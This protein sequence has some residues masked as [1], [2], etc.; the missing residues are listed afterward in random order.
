MHWLALLRLRLRSLRRAHLD[1]ELDDEMAFHV[2]ALTHDYTS[3]GLSETDA[4]HAALRDM[5]AIAGRK[6]EC[7]D[8]RRFAGIET[9]LTDI[10]YSARTLRKS[11][12]FTSVV[13]A[14]LAL[15][16]GACTTIFAFA[17][18]VLLRPLPYPAADRIVVLNEHA[19]GTTDPLAVH[20]LN[21]LEWRARA[22]AFETLA[23]AQQPPLNV[24]GAQ[25]AEQVAR[26]M[27]TADFLRVFGS[28]PVVG[29]DFSEADMRTGSD[30][31]AILGYGFWQRWFGGDRNVVG[32]QLQ[33]PDGSL[34]IV[35]VAPRAFRLGA[36]EPD[37][38][39]ALA[40][41]PANPSAT[42]SRAF[43][44]YGRLARG[45]SLETARA[46]MSTIAADL[47]VRHRLDEGMGV[48]VS[49]LHD[50]LSK[51]AR[52]GLRLL[53]AVVAT[54]LAIACV[55]IAGLLMARSAGRRPE[56]ALRV[57]LGASRGRL[58]RQVVIES[59]LLALMGGAIGVALAAWMTRAL[60]ALAAGPLSLAAFEAVRV[61]AT[62]V[63]FTLVVASA[64]ALA[65]GLLPAVQASHVGPDAALRGQARGSSGDVRQHRVRR[66]LV[67]TEV[68]LAVVL[69]VG[70]G[71]LVRTLANLVR[72][73]LGFQPA[74]TLTM[75]L[76]LGLT[77][78]DARIGLVDRILDRVTVLPGVAA[79]GT[80]QFPPLRG[81][82]CGTGF[83]R[84]EHAAAQDP[85]RTLPT[86]CGVTS[87]G[88][89][90]SM[91]IPVLAGRE[92]DRDDRVSSPRVVVVNQAFARKYFAG[93]AIGR[94]ILV[95]GTNQAVAEI[96]G[97]VG[98]VRH[99]GLTAE[100]V[101]TVF[102]THAQN[103]GYLTTLVVRATGDTAGQAAAIR[104][105]IHAVDP[106]QAVSAVGSLQQDVARVLAAPRLQATVV[107][108]AASA[109][110]LLA[111]IGV[112]GLMAYVVAERTRDIG[113]RLA[114]GARAR[115]IVAAM[116]GEGGRLVMAG[117]ALGTLVSLAL[118]RMLVSFV[119]GVTITDPLTYAIAGTVS[120]LAAL[121]ALIAPTLRATRIDPVT[122][123][124]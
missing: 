48:T 109:A 47:R 3:R 43:E 27:V 6:E 70:A 50:T 119:Y 72:V 10:R 58:L 34:T 44:C 93:D 115:D 61:D 76:F 57:A 37:V 82:T 5:G 17:N 62:S 24:M 28:G 78:P 85:A 69:L 107:A 73:N 86:S 26:V 87:R 71:L 30:R 118:S 96:V 74:Q 39:T 20:P 113:I 15:G 89:F 120:L 110:M 101:P 103:P 83:W 21:F 68:A 64:T 106:T 90:A 102:W 111:A 41:D 94:R 1:R 35:G 117:I 122:A 49:S 36:N 121:I 38:F 100:P 12:I 45:T 13:V 84:D 42:G 108:G 97:V 79:A 9:C 65:F 52:P 54:V 8:A 16:I 56:F 75:G 91:G 67:V 29:R 60:S 7:R 81:L 53:L 2:D 31:V 23:L 46:E 33:L 104:R 92:F 4:R 114:L 123:L 32:R 124:R 105:A 19:L 99:D 25:G 40:I 95:Q 77:P 59:L 22:Q 63:I 51:T 18:A 116:I 98:D 14:L 80:I 55:N 88:Y 66:V 11:P 112:Y